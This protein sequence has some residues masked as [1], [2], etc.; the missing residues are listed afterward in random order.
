PAFRLIS[1][2]RLLKGPDLCVSFDPVLALLL[3]LVQGAIG[4]AKELALPLAGPML[5]HAEAAGDP[6]RGPVAAVERALPEGGPDAL[7]ELGAALLVRSREEEDELL[8]APAAGE[9]GLAQRAAQD[10]RK[11]AQDVVA[12]VVAVPVVD[13]LEVVQV[14]DDE[15][16]GSDHAVGARDLVRERVLAA[17]PVRDSR[18]PVDER[19]ALDDRVQPRVLERDGGV[20]CE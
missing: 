14:G 9:V 6:E 19:L 4:L 20:R 7:G 10:A 1:G 15:R 12:C 5:G 11:L 3:G 17:A 18:Q 8:A 2:A 16:E 13:L